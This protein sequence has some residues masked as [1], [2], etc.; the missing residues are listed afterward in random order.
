MNPLLGRPLR[1]A[2]KAVAYALKHEFQQQLDEMRALI[3]ESNAYMTRQLLD[4][5]AAVRESAAGVDGQHGVDLLSARGLAVVY[6]VRAVSGLERGARILDLVP[7]STALA[8]SLASFGYPVWAASRQEIGYRHPNLTFADPAGERIDGEF[9][10]ILAILPT[11]SGGLELIRRFRQPGTL[12]VAAARMPPAKAL[13]RLIPIG[14]RAVQ[15]WRVEDRTFAEAGAD[16]SWT[17]VDWRAQ[18]QAGLTLVTAR[19]V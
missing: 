14:S 19:A 4:V 11:D 6:A 18:D 12:L 16:G 7:T 5:Q 9:G 13:D 15:G 17:P 3:V 1:F 2:R 10:A 8:Y